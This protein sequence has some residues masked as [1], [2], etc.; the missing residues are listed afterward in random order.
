MALLQ[1]LPINLNGGVKVNSGPKH[2][3]VKVFRNATE[4]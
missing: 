4:T 1:R 3:S 2:N